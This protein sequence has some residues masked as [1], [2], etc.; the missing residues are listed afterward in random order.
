MIF[1]ASDLTPQVGVTVGA[2]G[3]SVANETDGLGGGLSS[4]G[5]FLIGYGGGGGTVSSAGGYTYHTFTS[6]GTFALT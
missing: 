2:G 4:F 1:L 6:S 5:G 3:Q